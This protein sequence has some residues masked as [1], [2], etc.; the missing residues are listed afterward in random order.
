[1][2]NKKPRRNFRQ[3]KGESSDEEDENK[4]T[5]NEEEENNQRGA[6]SAGTVSKPPTC[7]GNREEEEEEDEGALHTAGKDTAEQHKN[8]HAALSFSDDR[9]GEYSVVNVYMYML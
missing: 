2:F 3:R 1:M 7:S 4:T 6:T 5:E 9:D 8:T